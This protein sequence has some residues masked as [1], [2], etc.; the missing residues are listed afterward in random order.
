MIARLNGLKN[1]TTTNYERYG[2]T[3]IA[4]ATNNYGCVTTSE[5]TV[6]EH[7]SV[8]REFLFSERAANVLFRQNF[9]MIC[10]RHSDLI[11]EPMTLPDLNSLK[12]SRPSARNDSRR[13]GFASANQPTMTISSSLKVN[14]A[15]VTTVLAYSSKSDSPTITTWKLADIDAFERYCKEY[16]SYG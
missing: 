6:P 5:C 13:S 3:W 10:L 14:N 16:P 8:G 15:S 2:Q 4:C 12:P 7:S 9:H 11:T 1:N